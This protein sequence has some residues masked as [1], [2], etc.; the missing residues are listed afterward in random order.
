[1]LCF[2]CGGRAFAS[3]KAEDKAHPKGLPAIGKWM[4]ETVPELGPARWVGIP[5]KGKRLI[6]PINIILVDKYAASEEDAVKRLIASCVLAGYEQRSGHASGYKACI[7]G[8]F[9]GQLP[10]KENHAFSNAPSEFN[11]NRGRI[12]GPRYKEGAYY[13][14]GAFSRERIIP[15]EQSQHRYVS[16]TQARDDFAKKFE[17]DTHYKISGRIRLNN[18]LQTKE[19]ATGDHDGFAVLLS[20]QR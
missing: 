6:E 3:A 20:A 19:E 8:I 13:F 10:E 15:L 5:F 12:F 1:M 7:D 2:C 11:N 18:V 14:I 16:F 9:Y 17:Q 4:L